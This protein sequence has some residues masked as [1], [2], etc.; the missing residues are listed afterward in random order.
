[1]I[2]SDNAKTLKGIEKELPLLFNHP[3]VKDEMQNRRIQWCFNLEQA[4]SWEGF[5]ERL[6]GSV[7]R[8][9]RKVLGNAQL[10]FDKLLT[11][12]SEVKAALNSRPLTYDY[13]IPGEELLTP[14]HV[15][16]K[17]HHSSQIS[18]S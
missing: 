11:V 4:P 18:T 9:L 15:R 1:M 3:Q 5:F 6:I 17:T 8:C 10:S 12:M 7:K 13:N 16:E 14:A 2:V